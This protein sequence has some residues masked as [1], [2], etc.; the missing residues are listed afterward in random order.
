M[1][2]Q[3]LKLSDASVNLSYFS[4]VTYRVDP[5]SLARLLPP[6]FKPVVMDDNGSVRGL[7]S[8]VTFKERNFSFQWMKPFQ[9]IP[10]WQTN[11]RAYVEDVL[12]GQRKVWFFQTMLGSVTA[13]IPKHLWKMPWERSSYHSRVSSSCWDIHGESERDTVSLKISPTNTPATLSGF[14]SESEAM[15]I[16]TNPSAGYFFNRNG[17]LSSYSIWH[18][19]IGNRSPSGESPGVRNRLLRRT[20]QRSLRQRP[21]CGLAIAFQRWIGST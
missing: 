8:A 3:S 11:Y 15:E 9:W 7:V 6:R 2:R 19:A 21:G 5:E 10:F 4:I 14:S 20:F 17:K 1:L 18:E 16:L 12:D 13:F